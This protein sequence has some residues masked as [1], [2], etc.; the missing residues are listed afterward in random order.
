[1]N[2]QEGLSHN[3]FCFIPADHYRH[4]ALTKGMPAESMDSSLNRLKT[5]FGSLERDPYSPGNRFRSHA[6]CRMDADERLQFGAYFD[7]FQT[8]EYNP[9]TGGII[10]RY[11]F[12]HSDLL[13]D[14]LFRILLN[15]DIQFID[16]YAAI[17]PAKKALISIHL[18][19]YKATP[20]SPAYSSP[21]WLHKD[22]E[23]VVFIHLIDKSENLLGGENLI[24]QDT[25]HI[26]EV[27]ELDECFDTLVLNHLKFHAVAPIGCK[28]KSKGDFSTRDVILITFQTVK[29]A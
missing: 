3:G 14:P 1:M 15:N 24:A 22:D 19:R 26:D 7:Y 20:G 8:K 5:A 13:E 29:P 12:I 27:L 18:F 2:Y 4:L 21:L 6:Q 11:K 10:R 17:G 23:D 25:K 9:D 28:S 16:R